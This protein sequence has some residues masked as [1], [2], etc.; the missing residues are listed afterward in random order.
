MGQQSRGPLYA[1]RTS[2]S[3]GGQGSW[4]RLA[5]GHRQGSL[6]GPGTAYGLSNPQTIDPDNAVLGGWP[7]RLMPVL[8][9]CAF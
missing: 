1:Q 3:R 9:T 6:S 5:I 7:F 4:L 8:V 2:L